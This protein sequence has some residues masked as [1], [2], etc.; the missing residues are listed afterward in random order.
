[1]NK[2]LLIL[3]IFIFLCI[4]FSNQNKDGYSNNIDRQG[5]SNNIDRQ[6]YYDDFMNKYY[7]EMFPDRNRNAGGP[8]FYKKISEISHELTEEEFNASYIL[9]WGEWFSYSE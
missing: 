5:Y 1:M 9:L 4:C 2:Y 7:E 6:E 8:M 3:I